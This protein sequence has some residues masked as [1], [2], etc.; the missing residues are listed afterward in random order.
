MKRPETTDMDAE[1]RVFNTRVP[2]SRKY[3][4]TKIFVLFR[5]RV[6]VIAFIF[7]S[8]RHNLFM[9]QYCNDD[10]YHIWQAFGKQQSF[11]VYSK[12]LG[13]K[14]RFVKELL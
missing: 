12:E 2:L 10:I 4:S 11:L 9:T 14:N 1:K 5:F 13:Y 7:Y 6:F 3:E 8:K